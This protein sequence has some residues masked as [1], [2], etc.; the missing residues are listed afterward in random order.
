MGGTK[1]CHHCA[2]PYSW[3]FRCPC[4]VRFC[5]RE[6]AELAWPLH[7]RSCKHAQVRK[8]LRAAGLKKPLATYVLKFVDLRE[9]R[10]AEMSAD[11]RC[12]LPWAGHG[13]G[14]AA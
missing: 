1:P 9:E 6:C 10:I 7:R 12:L 8:I 5:G 14:Q 4:G 11:G 3:G 2:F 13:G